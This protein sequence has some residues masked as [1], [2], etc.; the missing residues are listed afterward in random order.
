MKL[1]MNDSKL[2]SPEHIR[3]FLAGTCKVNMAIA[4]PERY[5][6]L[7]KTLKQTG[8]FQ[9]RKKEKATVREYM[10]KM[11]GYSR[12]QLTRLIK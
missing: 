5:A 4:K 10:Q 3:A 6:W 11:S 1:Q 9:L 12:Q 8:Y 2:K 7:A